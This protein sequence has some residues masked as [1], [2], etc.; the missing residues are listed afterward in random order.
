MTTPTRLTLSAVVFAALP[1]WA[2]KRLDEAVAKAETQ[3]AKGKTDDAVK[4]LQQAAGK[5]PRDPEPQLALARLQAR[6]GKLDEA[7]LTY[8]KAGTLAAT[9]APGP[10][11]RVL[12]ARSVFTLRGGTTRE[13]LALARQAVEAE[14]GGESLGALARAQARAGDPAA[15]AT[16][17]KAVQMAPRSAA[18][19]L[20]QGDAL[21]T[22]RLATEAEA[23][24]RRA[25]ELE[26]T[27]AAAA[28]GVALALAGQGKA[29]P[30]L[31]ASRSAAQLDPHL[32]E[33]VAAQG[34]AA[35]AQDPLDKASEAISAVQQAAMLEPKNAAVKLA[36]GRVFESRGQLEEAVAAYHEAARLDPT[37]A[38][39]Q[40]AALAVPLPGT[41]TK[42]T[43]ASVRALP[44]DMKASADAQLLLG[45]LLLA[46]QEWD[47]ANV[48]LDRA[49]AAR[50][51]L[52]EAHALQGTA[53]Y[54]V[55]DLK[56]AAD[57]HGR[58]AALE[59]GNATYAASHGLYLAYDGRLEEGLAALLAVT[60]RP[61]G[62]D[63]ASFVRLGWIYRSLKP[64]RVEDAVGAYQRALKLDPRNREAALGVPQSHRAG[65]QWARA[66]E[67][68]ERL[69]KMNP[70]L[71]GEAMLGVAWCYLLSGDDYK[72]R[73]YVGLAAKEGADVGGIR[74]ALSGS[75]AAGD[76]L[77]ELAEELESKDAGDQVRAVRRLVALGRPGVPTLAAALPRK[78]T[79]LATR[80]A[81]AEGLGRLGPEARAALPQ[82]ERLIAAGTQAPAD[83]REARVIEALRSAAD[84]IR[85]K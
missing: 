42:G 54:H 51:G 85:G 48:V 65:K 11:A 77:A 50:P 84:K 73:F 31:E 32:A 63:A 69:P 74:R 22:A 35:L 45:K 53:A 81:I 56:R 59:P 17:A 44:E 13:A 55:G 64:P 38:A 61:E 82:V 20:A 68:Y 76:E 27:S 12:A 8:D 3:L 26:R 71:E 49:V 79:S 21:W 75:G 43:L 40:V 47:E 83:S 4:I 24:Y 78:T 6:L 1:A 15:R 52:A 23:A 30:A 25:L 60:A 66:I 57:A 19:H 70:R 10:K 7:A 33:A 16:A 46:N 41:D 62:Q 34:M 80:E 29:A 9:A 67:A 2:D 14:A 18:A 37:W 5:A 72:A 36:V 58:A 28:T 39:P